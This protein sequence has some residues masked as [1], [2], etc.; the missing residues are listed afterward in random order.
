MNLVVEFL[1][2]C[3]LIK[4]R[5]PDPIGTKSWHGNREVVKTADGWKPT[6]K[7][8]T[9]K[10]KPRK[11]VDPKQAAYDKEKAKLAEMR[12]E[13]RQ[14]RADA[15]RYRSTPLGQRS[16]LGSSPNKIAFQLQA[17]PYSIRAQQQKV[18]ELQ[19]G[20]PIKRKT[21]GK[22]KPFSVEISG[23]TS[24]Q[25]DLERRI[26]HFE[27]YVR[28]GKTD[29]YVTAAEVAE[30]Q[31]KVDLLRQYVDRL[32]RE[33][34]PVELTSIKQAVGEKKR[35]ESLK[36]KLQASFGD[37]RS[38]FEDHLL[39]RVYDA[40]TTRLAQVERALSNF[41]FDP[42]A[43]KAIS[44]GDRPPVA[45][46]LIRHPRVTQPELVRMEFSKVKIP[47]NEMYGCVALAL[48]TFKAKK[49]PSSRQYSSAIDQIMDDGIGVKFKRRRF[50]GQQRRNFGVQLAQVK[51]LYDR[52]GL[53]YTVSRVGDTTFPRNCILD[54]R[55]SK[56]DHVA[57]RI[58][59]VVRDGFDIRTDP[60]HYQIIGYFT[61]K[62]KKK[63]K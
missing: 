1:Q 15:N 8:R 11:R 9:A 19:A 40:A 13:L 58:N 23:G 56:G 37:K 62:K 6:G 63:S 30:A 43:A 34:P 5:K 50:Q 10:P 60:R 17:L 31:G 3:D 24:Q 39:D 12:V 25:L 4:G 26:S 45:S 35:L 48:S 36:S 2:N 59:G 32:K 57:A 41:K 14:A 44:R 28:L 51:A 47:E 29:T 18:K 22:S 38:M 49:A 20:L 54:L 16:A 21:S 33:F 52:H 42:T 55:G 53:E 27:E 46:T 7:V 61:P